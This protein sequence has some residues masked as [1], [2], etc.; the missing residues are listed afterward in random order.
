MKTNNKLALIAT[1]LLLSSSAQANFLKD[2]LDKFGSINKEEKSECASMTND[3]VASLCVEEVC[4]DASKNPIIFNAQ[5]ARDRFH[6]PE[7]QAKIDEQEQ[8]LRNYEQYIKD[9]INQFEEAKKEINSLTADQ[10]S[11]Q[12]AEELIRDIF[13]EIKDEHK[14]LNKLTKDISKNDTVKIVIPPGSRYAGIYK[15]VISKINVYDNVEMAHR[16]AL[17]NLDEERIF[18][19]YLQKAK[20]LQEELTK[21]GQSI[22][23]DFQEREEKL[24]KAGKKHSSTYYS[25]LIKHAKNA[26]IELEKAACDEACKKSLVTFMQTKAKQL[27]VKEMANQALEKFDFEDAIAECKATMTLAS[28]KA[29]DTSEMEKEYPKLIEKFK[30]N[31]SLKFSD[32][33]KD[34]LLKKIDKDLKVNFNHNP[35]EKMQLGV[36]PWRKEVKSEPHTSLSTKYIAVTNKDN[37][38]YLVKVPRCKKIEKVATISDAVAYDLQKNEG[39]LYVSPFSCEHTHLGKEIMAHE[40]GHAVSFMISATAGMSSETQDNFSK[41][42]VCSRQEKRSTK[43]PGLFSPHEGDKW[44]TEEDTA[45]LFSFALSENKEDFMGCAL[46]APAGDSYQGLKM[47]KSFLDTHS[48]GIQRLMVELQYKNPGKIT[49]ACAEVI[50]RS[51][52]KITKQCF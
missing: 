9:E 21:K 45:D 35:Y 29:R 43:F 40:L 47:R 42:R 27:D 18:N 49:E 26:G 38:Q 41:M 13:F 17:S 2:L 11:D 14:I 6:S 25:D 52:A 36:E 20:E 32:H 24:R 1:T 33:S 23:Y 3:E 7:M 19:I 50:K 8:I 31:K 48:A 30:N 15:E 28:I 12:D 10:I 44:T 5:Q 39:Q 37:A 34:L 16:M 46:V 51:K 4:G 22:N